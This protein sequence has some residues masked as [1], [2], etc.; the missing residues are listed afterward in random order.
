VPEAP[1]RKCS[2][3]G[4]AFVLRRCNRVAV[5]GKGDVAFVQLLGG[6][7]GETPTDESLKAWKNASRGLPRGPKDVDYSVNVTAEVFAA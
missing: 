5:C 1:E 3:D 2:S 4:V 6:L 7:L